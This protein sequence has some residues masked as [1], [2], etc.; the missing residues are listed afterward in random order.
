LIPSCSGLARASR[1][2]TRLPAR[3]GLRPVPADIWA[4]GLHS[5]AA[6][7]LGGRIAG[8]LRLESPAS[9]TRFYLRGTEEQRTR[10]TRLRQSP[11]SR[12]PIGAP[13]WSG[14][15][16]IQPRWNFVPLS[17]LSGERATRSS[18]VSCRLPLRSQAHTVRTRRASAPLSTRSGRHA[19]RSRWISVSLYLCTSQINPCERRNCRGP[20]MKGRGAT[21]DFRSLSGWRFSFGP[22]RSPRRLRK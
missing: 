6:G 4:A 19:I 12:P 2:A 3:S 18:W 13:W 1:G 22:H 9:A 11:A 20:L 21:D 15:N 16:A 10:A 7:L 14:R 5:G 17:L 8:W